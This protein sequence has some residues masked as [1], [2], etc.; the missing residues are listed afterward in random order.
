MAC[1]GEMSE[2]QVKRH[3]KGQLSLITREGDTG[4]LKGL[5]VWEERVI[6]CLMQG[7]G[8]SAE[9]RGWTSFL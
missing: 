5:A 1:P 6:A 7:P 9:R 4:S 8:A 2:I 3:W